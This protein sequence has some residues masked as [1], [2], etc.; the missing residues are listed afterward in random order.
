MVL[1]N[2]ANS[3]P[4]KNPPMEGSF[5]PVLRK[6]PAVQG[7]ALLAGQEFSGATKIRGFSQWLFLVP[8]K[9]SR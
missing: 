8:L 3:S 9:G 6:A 5:Q 7:Q 4:P 2:T 1:Q